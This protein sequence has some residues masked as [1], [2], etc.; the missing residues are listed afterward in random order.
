[1]KRL[2][3]GAVALALL[4]CGGAFAQGTL[5][6]STFRTTLMALD[7]GTK[8]ATATSGAATLNKS[9]GVITSEALSTAAAST[10]TLTLTNSTI[11]ATDQVFASVS[12]GT[13]T[14]GMPCI[15]TTKPGAGSVVIVVQNVAASG[16]LNGTI[17][18][19]FHVLKN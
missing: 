7:S 5:N 8:T 11:A 16:A 3:I 4:A 13:S 14:T 1:M 9:A 18:I 19:A 6:P 15:T 17:K 2:L 12:T 10:Y